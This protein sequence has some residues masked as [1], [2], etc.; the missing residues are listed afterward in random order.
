[1]GKPCKFMEKSTSHSRN[2][3]ANRDISTRT[4]IFLDTADEIFPIKRAF[5]VS[6]AKMFQ[7]QRPAC[8]LFLGRSKFLYKI[9]PLNDF[10]VPR[11]SYHLKAYECNNLQPCN[12]KI[13]LMG[14]LKYWFFIDISWRCIKTLIAV[15]VYLIVTSY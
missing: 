12:T 1:M 8:S 4:R 6:S 11:S 5:C 7:M 3:Y 9:W 13:C 14:H 10:S 2:P 15:V